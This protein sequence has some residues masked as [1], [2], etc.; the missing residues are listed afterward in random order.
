MRLSIFKFIRLRY[1]MWVVA[2]MRELDKN[3]DFK[4]DHAWRTKN[5]WLIIYR[6]KIEQFLINEYRK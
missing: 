3:Y 6:D 2:S 4:E 5:R 1:W